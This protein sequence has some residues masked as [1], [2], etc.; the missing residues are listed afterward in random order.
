MLNSD[1][2]GLSFYED[3]TGKYV[4]GAD[5]VPKKLG[6]N[7][8]VMPELW[9]YVGGANRQCQ[10]AYKFNV[11]D[12]ETFYIEKIEKYNNQWI[13]YSFVGTT[14]GGISTNLSYSIGKDMNIS[15]YVLLRITLTPGSDTG[16][17]S[18]VRI[19]NL[20]IS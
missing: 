20:R 19:T 4:M 6:K 16:K 9:A 15:P 18:F 5:S 7:P 2:G 1:L 8:I 13:T 14:S 12:Y 17:E 3:A 11:E 10:V